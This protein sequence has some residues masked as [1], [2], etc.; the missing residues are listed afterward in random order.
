MTHKVT[1]TY[2]SIK[3]YMFTELHRCTLCLFDPKYDGTNE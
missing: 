1:Q 2:F 3:V